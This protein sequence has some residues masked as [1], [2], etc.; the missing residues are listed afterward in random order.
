MPSLAT[1]HRQQPESSSVTPQKSSVCACTMGRNI[2]KF[3]GE[4]ALYHSAIGVDHIFIYD[5]G[6][7][8]NLAQRL[9]QLKSAGLNITIVSW[10]WTKTQE[11]GLSHCAAT[12]QGSC[13]WMAVMD[14]D[15]FIFSTSWIGLE[16]PSKS[17]LARSLQLMT[18]LARYTLRVMILPPRAKQNIH[19]RGSARATPVS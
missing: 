8:D 17:L 9:A 4:W 13:T 6:S 2:V 10:P 14:V 18:P 5:N 1:F 15:E 19:Q 7:K 3:L 16:M 11:D 12:Q